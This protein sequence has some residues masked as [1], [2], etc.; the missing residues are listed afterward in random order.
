LLTVLVIACSSSSTSNPN[1]PTC[2]GIVN[3]STCP[4]PTPSWT[5][6][7]EPLV[8]KYC[9]QCHGTG[10]SAQGNADLSSYAG[11]K[12]K[13]PTVLQQVSS[14]LMPNCGASP[15]PM[16]YPTIAERNTIIAWAGVCGA[17]DN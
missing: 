16:A 14:C 3:P 8:V 13:A 11:V 15:P 6:D 9:W 10:G 12:K 5:N 7:V 2:S 4:T 17:P 1:C